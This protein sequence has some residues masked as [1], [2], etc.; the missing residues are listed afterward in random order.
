MTIKDIIEEYGR[1]SYTITLVLILGAILILWLITDGP[2]H[3]YE[4]TICKQK[5]AQLCFDNGYYGYNS[6]KAPTVCNKTTVVEAWCNEYP[7]GPFNKKVK[8]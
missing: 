3:E 8:E 7:N 1:S 5:A 2:Q 6:V 4:R